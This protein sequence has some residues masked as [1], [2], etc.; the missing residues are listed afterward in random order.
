LRCWLFALA[1]L[2]SALSDAAVGAEPLIKDIIIYQ[3]GGWSGLGQRKEEFEWPEYGGKSAYLSRSPDILAHQMSLI[4]DLGPHVAIA[5]LLMTD[6]DSEKS[7][8][9]ACWNGEW[10][11][12]TTCD[13]GTFL[14]PFEM[15]DHVRAAACA[16]GV[17]YAPEFSL[18][19]YD[20]VRGPDVLPKLQQA[21]EWW[22]LRLPDAHAAKSPADRYYVVV[23]SLPEQTNLSEED[24]ANI[25]A[26]MRSQSDIDWID[27]MVHANTPPENRFYRGNIYHSIWGGN[28]IRD[29]L[30]A[31]QGDHLLWTY[32]T[33]ET[34]RSYSEA[35]AKGKVMSLAT[36]LKWMNVEPST[37]SK[38]PVLIHQWN[39]Y[40]EYHIFEPS[41]KAGTANYD[42]LKQLISQ[43]P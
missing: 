33:N 30:N 34:V 22:R 15:Y 12:Q 4:A 13:S 38:Y 2:A 24:K 31:Q 16:A 41:T 21:I 5:V 28:A 18:M 29:W 20:G 17:R 6:T 7:G 27:M 10:S 11:G 37:P 39:E 19:N 40:G 43:Q 42:Y 35:H 26:Y 3:P 32:Y 36:Q 23:D 14:R 1:L 25:I 9:G 8:Y